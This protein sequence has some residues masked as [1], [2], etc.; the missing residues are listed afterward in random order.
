MKT[1]NFFPI[2]ALLVKWSGIAITDGRG[3]IGGTVLS[4]SKAG[5]TARNKV[6]PINRRTSA[7]S[8]IRAI[9]TSFSQMFRTLTDAQITAWNAASASGFTTT[10]IFGDTIKKSGSMLFTSLNVNLTL[11]GGTAI[12]DPPNKNDSPSGVLALDPTSD[13]SSSN[14]FM[15]ASFI[16]DTDVVPADNT[17]VVYATP[18]LSNG[19]SFVRSQL[20]ILKSIPASTDTGTENLW[21]DYTTKYGSPAVNDNIVFA[22][23]VINTISGIAG[24]PIQTRVVISA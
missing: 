2:V 1:K 21:A 15:N 6:T 19:V 3:K 8:T 9:F 16:G 20:R 13:V 5:A 18:K 22:V 4:K 14:I 24:T 7:Q 10:N 23:Q 17:M 12:S 11:A